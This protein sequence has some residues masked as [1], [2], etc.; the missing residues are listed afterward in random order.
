MPV[1]ALPA[2]ASG[3]T[4]WN[5]SSLD[6]ASWS[7]EARHG[8]LGPDI[9]G[10]AARAL[11]HGPGFAL[12]SGIDLDGLDDDACLGL[13]QELGACFGT[14][15][16]LS[17]HRRADNA[18]SPGTRTP[19]LDADDGHLDPH[20]D[21]CDGSSV[22]DLMALLCVRQATTGGDSLL[23]SGPTVHN[24]LRADHP[25]QLQLLYG[26]QHFG[27]VDGHVRRSP[28]F[29]QDGGAVR[30]AYNRFHMVRALHERGLSPTSAQQAA[31][32]AFDHTLHQPGITLRL[33]LRPGDLLLVH[34]STVL[35]GRTAFTHSPV[36]R[37]LLTR[38]W[39]DT[40]RPA[41]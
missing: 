31:F 6:G 38:T 34:N 30:V 9:A 14:P 39:I 36:A 12:V 18:L 23:A 11:H 32:A 24:H 2:P 22:A 10:A 20:T 7:F 40:V 3:P 4:V 8:R 13:S 37:R 28:V 21:R 16:P 26:D 5:A 1:V 25:D 27:T 29:R 33:R 19:G 17:G 35:H 41:G 15:R